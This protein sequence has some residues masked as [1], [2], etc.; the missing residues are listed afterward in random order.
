MNNNKELEQRER[1]LNEIQTRKN[2]EQ[3]QRTITKTAD[4]QHEQ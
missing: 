1:T 4:K 2:N 3:E